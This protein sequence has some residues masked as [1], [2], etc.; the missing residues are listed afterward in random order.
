MSAALGIAPANDDEFLAVEALGLEP[1]TP[2]GLVSARD[3]LRYD[4]FQAVLAG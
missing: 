1:S 4:A 3:T 2:V